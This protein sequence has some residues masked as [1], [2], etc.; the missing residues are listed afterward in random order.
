MIDVPPESQVHRQV[1]RKEA[2]AH[3]I[4]IDP[5][6]RLY[7][8]EVEEPDLAS[9]SSDL[10]RLREALEREWELHR[11][12]RSTITCTPG[13]C[14]RRCATG[15]WKVTVAVHDDTD[16]DRGLAGL[17]RH[18]VRHRVRHRLD[19]GRRAPL[20]SRDRRGARL[21][22][23]DEPADPL[24]RGSDEPRLVRDDEPRLREGAD[25]RRARLPREADGRALRGGAASRATTSSR[26]RSSATRSCT[27][28]CSASTRPSSAARRSRS[29]STRRCAVRAHR[30]R[31]AGQPR[32]ARLRAAVH[33]RATSAPTPPA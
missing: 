18:V 12:R 23:R 19:H 30:A 1:V 8:V 7:Y 29:R 3:P 5:V 32:R 4:E 28:F 6:V 33:R 22:R 10:G 17:P 31:A 25:A 2:D 27:T 9:P 26:S 20:R 24:R 16:A 13:L 15:E 11:S 21:G 14:R